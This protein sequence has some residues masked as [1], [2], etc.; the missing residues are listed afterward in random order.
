MVI[1]FIICAMGFFA[2][3][4]MAYSHFLKHAER[5]SDRRCQQFKNK[6]YVNNRTTRENTVS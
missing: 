2:F 4:W 3:G 1:G 5:R 6:K